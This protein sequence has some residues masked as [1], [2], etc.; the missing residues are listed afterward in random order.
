MTFDEIDLLNWN[1][2]LEHGLETLQTS[3][4]P[5]TIN[6]TVSKMQ[7]VLTSAISLYPEYMN[8]VKVTVDIPKA[9]SHDRDD[10]DP[11][12]LY[13]KH[14][15]NKK[16]IPDNIEHTFVQHLPYTHQRELSTDSF[17]S[18]RNQFFESISINSGCYPV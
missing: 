15:L 13:I 6:R 5:N 12:E 3:K 7:T 18:T 9:L 16:T 11:L 2:H 1:H 4:D 17:K 10:R 8:A 14:T